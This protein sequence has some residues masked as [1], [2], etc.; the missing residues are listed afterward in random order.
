MP[1]TWVLRTRAAKDKIPTFDV[2]D[3]SGRVVSRVAL[4][5][6]TRLVGFG[7]G[8]VYLARSDED[9]LQY[10]QRHALPTSRRP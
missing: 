10:L 7:N 5:Q 3:A 8:T 1:T 6:D 9:D 4:P 2:F